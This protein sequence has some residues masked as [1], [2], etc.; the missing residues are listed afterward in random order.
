MITSSDFFN[1]SPTSENI[2]QKSDEDQKTRLMIAS[3]IGDSAYVDK[4]LEMPGIDADLFDRDG[5]NALML[6]VKAGHA[7]I[8]EKLV[9]LT[10]L[11]HVNNQGDSVFY[12]SE[13]IE[14]NDI[15]KRYL[16]S[17]K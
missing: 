14:V 9:K 7:D 3:Q 12:L 16:P 10:D 6:A 4:L 13:N 5:H 11:G 15:L 2:N 17:P 8:V 1:K